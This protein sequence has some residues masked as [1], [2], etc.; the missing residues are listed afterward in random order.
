VH[1]GEKEFDKIETRSCSLVKAVRRRRAFD[2][3]LFL[4]PS[5]EAPP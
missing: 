3:E 1:D 2:D 4:S 5:V